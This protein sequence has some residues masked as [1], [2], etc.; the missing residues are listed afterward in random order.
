MRQWVEAH[1]VPLKCEDDMRVFPQSDNG[2]DVVGIFEKIF[3]E[4]KVRIHFKE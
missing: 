3:R 1:G 4:K 2:G